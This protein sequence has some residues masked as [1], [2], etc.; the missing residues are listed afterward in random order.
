M[1]KKVINTPQYL[2]LFHITHYLLPITYYSLPITYY[3]LPI[4]L[5]TRNQSQ[6]IRLVA[7]RIPALEMGFVFA[8][9]FIES[10]LQI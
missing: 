9:C 3:L 10:E 2:R 4:E 6:A 8:C 5:S 7:I 1:K